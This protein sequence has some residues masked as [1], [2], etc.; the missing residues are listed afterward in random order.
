M[1]GAERAERKRKQQ[2]AQAAAT[3]TTPAVA[4]GQ[5]KGGR[6]G[7]AV[8]VLVAVLALLVGGGIWLQQRG[9][10]LPPAIPAAAPGPAY[11]VAVQGD[12]VVSGEPAAPVTIDVYEDFLCSGCGQF[13]Q[14]YG[15][16]LEAAAAAGQARV[17]Y[18]PVAILDE[19][20]DPAGY[21]TLAAGSALCAADAG[22]FPRFHDSLFDTQPLGS[23]PAW[24]T[25]Q[26]QQL[27][28]ALGAGPE[29]ARC[30]A[31]EHDERISRAT[32]QAR[33]FLTERRPDGRFGTPTVLVNGA[34]ADTSD[35]GWL[36]D[37]L[38]AA[39]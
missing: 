16:Q 1:G 24:D 25:A 39:R 29:F 21:S 27:G 37:A 34:I 30:V 6:R 2:A 4:A 5:G 17:V 11:P 13:E 15:G 10:D 20:S 14:L 3:E 28:G 22:I 7:A 8:V 18:H 31:A 35:P 36:D 23:G 12:A 38:G 26:L 9:P 33:Q 19:Y 32:E